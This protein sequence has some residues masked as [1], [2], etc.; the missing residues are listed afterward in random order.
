MHSASN[1]QFLTIR[2]SICPGH[3]QIECQDLGGPWHRKP[4]DYRPHGLNIVEALTGPGNWGTKTTADGDRIVWARLALPRHVSSQNRSGHMP[5][6]H[7]STGPDTK[8]DIE[9]V[10][11]PLEYTR[12]LH[13]ALDLLEERLPSAHACDGL[14]PLITQ[15]TQAVEILDDL[16]LVIRLI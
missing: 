2:V 12:D 10:R 8:L 16:G 9:E 11:R 5:E 1:G 15:A 4:A 7:A 14:E 3:V 13:M 6:P